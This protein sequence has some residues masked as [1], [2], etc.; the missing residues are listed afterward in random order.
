[1]WGEEESRGPKVDSAVFAQEEDSTGEG[2]PVQ[3]RLNASPVP[4][5]WH[6]TDHGVPSF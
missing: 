4:V 5:G 6:A 2:N 1:M 3:V